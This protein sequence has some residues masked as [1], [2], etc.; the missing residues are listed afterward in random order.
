MNLH[1]SNGHLEADINIMMAPY[2][3]EK[4]CRYIHK[5]T[6]IHLHDHQLH[7]L[8]Q[9]VTRACKKFGYEYCD[10][11]FSVLE[12]SS[13]TSPELEYLIAGI[14]VG[15]TYFFRD[16]A[17]ISYLRRHWLPRILKEKQGAG[18]KQLRIWSAGCAS[19]EELYSMAMLVSEA[20]GAEHDWNIHLL[21]T[22]INAEILA[23][24]FAGRYKSWSFRA[25]SNHMRNKYFT[26][27]DHEYTV[28]PGLRAH[29]N[30]VY[31]NL[32]EDN[33]PAILTGTNNLD[34]ILCRN[35]FIYFSE[36]V[37]RKILKKLS[38]CL[39]IDGILMLGASDLIQQ[40]VPGFCYQL[41]DKAGFYQRDDKPAKRPAVQLQQKRPHRTAP[42]GR[43]Q[44]TAALS[45]L[46]RLP[47]HQQGRASVSRQYDNGTCN[48]KSEIAAA[49][50]AVI[51]EL[52][53]NEHWH[54]AL[55]AIVAHN[56]KHDNSALSYQWQAKI[57]ANLGQLQQAIELCRQSL[58][59]DNTEKHTHFLHGMILAGLGDKA[60]AIAALRKALYL[61]RGFIEAHFQLGLLLLGCDQRKAGLK[62]L[63]NALEL[64]EKCNPQHSVHDA[65]GLSIGRLS[66]I[67]IQEIELYTQDAAGVSP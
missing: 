30:F 33:F 7:L 42:I 13:A 39:N 27:T 63:K 20:L 34:L 15:E 41:V 4:L 46:G 62:S 37:I 64:V 11:Y 32:I 5:R 16:D 9:T 14:T 24:A 38:H 29:T 53:Y 54:E 52:L 43:V 19:G 50:K 22:D 40:S 65:P 66:E 26:S 8:R 2:H 3:E 56:A 58:A 44:Q 60:G 28:K 1:A 49:D 10:E 48:D 21:G 59:L 47:K 61:D 12:A 36:D 23:K 6:G 35:V 55:A 18:D 51:T 25:T 31:L 17:Q 67:L 57:Q 45:T